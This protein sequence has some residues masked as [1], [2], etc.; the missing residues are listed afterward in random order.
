M[1]YRY[2]HVPR[3]ELLQLIAEREGISEEHI[4]LGSGSGQVLMFYA[5]YLEK[6]ETMAGGNVVASI[7][8]YVRFT[9]AMEKAGCESRL[10][11]LNEELTDDLPAMATQIDENTKCVY[12]CNPNNP[13][14]AIANP[15]ALR[16]FVI[17]TAKTCPVMVDE[18]YL[19]CSDDFETN[20]MA[21][22]VRAGHDVIVVRTFSK[23]YGMA[24]ARVGYGIVGPAN[25]S[26]GLLDFADP[27]QQ[28]TRSGLVAAIASLKDTGYVDR[29]RL[30]IK[31]ERDKLLALLH[32]FGCHYSEPQGNF[33]F[34]Q[35]EGISTTDFRAEM[36]KDGL[37]VARDFPP[38]LDWCRI[39]I[40]S[41]DE[42][43]LARNAIT[44]I[45]TEVLGRSSAEVDASVSA[46]ATAG[47]SHHATDLARL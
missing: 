45:M 18:A 29:T 22:L 40:G 6:V 28:F 37:Q 39:S 20:T 31:S 26:K 24:G 21:D 47:V 9:D 4:C 8:S 7:P 23:I 35:H 3:Q 10:V 43:E 5:G 15:A 11:P 44:R 13:T 42:M 38:Y 33:V 16:E 36:Q 32:E 14:G 46:V 27:L 1:S 17:E 34:F 30:L 19:E 41:P 2:S 25:R 12:I